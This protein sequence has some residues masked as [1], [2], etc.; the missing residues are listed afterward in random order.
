MTARSDRN[1]SPTRGVPITEPNP[2]ST[3]AIQVGEG[4]GKHAALYGPNVRRP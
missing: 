4:T 2:A 1:D 3:P